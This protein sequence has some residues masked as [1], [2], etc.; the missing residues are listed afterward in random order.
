MPKN[1]GKCFLKE[2]WSAVSN[3]VK[4]SEM[5]EEKRLGNLTTRK[6][7]PSLPE[8]FQGSGG[9]ESRGSGSAGGGERGRQI[10]KG[11]WLVSVIFGISVFLWVE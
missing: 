6:W 10:G 9:Q 5:R 11:T 7:K 2:V 4:S 3:A 8:K 1:Q